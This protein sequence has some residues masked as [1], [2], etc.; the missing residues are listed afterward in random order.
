MSG[1]GLCKD[2]SVNVANYN[3]YPW[4]LGNVKML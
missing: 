3:N 1:A 2:L 4:A